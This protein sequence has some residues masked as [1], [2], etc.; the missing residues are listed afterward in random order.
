MFCVNPDCPHTT[1]AKTFAFL[2]PKGKKSQRLQDKIVNMSLHVSS[3]TASELLKNGIADVGKSTICNL[4]KKDLPLPQKET[5]TKVCIDDF[6]IRKR[7]TYGTVMVDIESRRMIDLLPLREIEDV[8][9]W[10]KT[11]PNLSI[12]SRDGSVSYHYAI[13]QANSAIVQIV[14]LHLNVTQV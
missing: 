9:E 10:P 12:V 13:S 4:L 7:H 6:A 3:L 14:D 2:P 5:V 8:V 1:F 11:Y